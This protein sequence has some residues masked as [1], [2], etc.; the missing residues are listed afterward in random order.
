MENNKKTSDIL[1][2]LNITARLV[3][4]CAVIALLVATVNYF[5]APVIERNNA[6][7]TRLAIEELFGQG[8][9]YTDLETSDEKI[10]LDTVYSVNLGESFLG[11]C[12]KLSPTGFKGKVDLLVAFDGQGFVKNVKVTATNDETA[13]IGTKVKD[14]SFTDKFIGL[15]EGKKSASEYVISGA[16]KTSKPVS[17]AILDATDKIGAL[18]SLEESEGTANE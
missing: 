6:E 17:Q 5:T 18:I 2:V 4:V 9:T 13:D 11:Y 15:P 1:Y 7:A 8:V 3:A 12:A 10:S 14:V 16:T